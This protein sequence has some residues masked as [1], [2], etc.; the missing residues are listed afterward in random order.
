MKDWTREEV[1]A[2]VADYFDMLETEQR[3]EPVNKAAHR[4]ALRKI[5]Q[6]SEGSIEFKHQ[7]ISAVLIEL[8]CQY[9]QGYKPRRNYQ[10]LLRDV[11]VDRLE[12]S[13][14]LR[15]LLETAAER[16][17]D[18]THVDDI[19]SILVPP[20]RS[21]GTPRRSDGTSRIREAHQRSSFDYIARE[22]RNQSLGA[23]GELLVLDYEH[24][25]LWTAGNKRLAERIEHVARTQGDHLGFDIRSFEETGADRLIEVKT[26]RSGEMTPFFVT[27]N[28][29]QVSEKRSGDYHLYRVHRFDAGPKMF[30]L[31]GALPD[32]CVLD[33]TVF[34]ARVR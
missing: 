19:L 31:D 34:K 4:R 3:G 29:V 7:N 26:T 33:P 27:R 2:T 28:E 22:Q 25:R 5:V 24:R 15:Q 12:A 20:P 23:A 30:V 9:V 14:S 10:D 1:E 11:I 17:A 16:P 6:R 21:E 13:P 8:G 32:A 18:P